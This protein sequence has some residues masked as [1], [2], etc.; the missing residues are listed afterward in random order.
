MQRLQARRFQAWRRTVS[1]KFSA[2][3]RADEAQGSRYEGDEVEEADEG[4][5]IHEGQT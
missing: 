3:D 5:E 1:C 2:A 4:Y